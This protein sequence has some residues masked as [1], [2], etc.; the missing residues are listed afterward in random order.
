MMGAH[1]MYGEG[2]GG[3]GGGMI[4]TVLHARRQELTVLSLKNVRVCG[5]VVPCVKL[6][7]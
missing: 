1:L 7:Y 6:G 4:M 2:S 5:T 3:V